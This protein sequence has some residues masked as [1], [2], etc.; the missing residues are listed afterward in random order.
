MIFFFTFVGKFE[1]Q[2]MECFLLINIFLLAC[3]IQLP[4]FSI[5]SF[6]E[7]DLVTEI[8][9]GMVITP[10][11]SCTFGRDSNPQP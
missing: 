2:D 6:N 9:P 11:P 4:I 3:P 1:E 5:F 7:P 10:F 8:D